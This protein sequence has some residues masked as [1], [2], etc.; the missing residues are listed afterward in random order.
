MAFWR[1]YRVLSRKKVN[2][3]LGYEIELLEESKPFVGRLKISLKRPSRIRAFYLEKYLKDL[4][5]AE[6]LPEP[7]TGEAFVG[8]EGIDI[9][10]PMLENIYSLQRSDWKGALASVKGIYLITDTNNGK[11]CSTP[12][13]SR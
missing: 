3:S 7:Y 1:A 5:V 13:R 4:A 9:S 12:R 8:Y 10:F 11:R 6:I 2:N